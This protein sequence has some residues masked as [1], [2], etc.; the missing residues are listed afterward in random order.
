MFNTNSL[1][2]RLIILLVVFAFLPACIS[3]I[4]SGYM[5]SQSIIES[6]IVAN[7]SMAN[8]VGDEIDLLLEE[9]RKE[10]EILAATPTAKSMDATAVKELILGAQK[11][12]PSF[13]LIVVMDT[14]GNQIART[15]GTLTN[16][17]DRIYFQEAMK[18]HTFF[19]D[20]YISAFTKAPC[21]TVAVPVKNTMGQVVGVVA[22]D[23]SLKVV[24]DIIDVV[25]VGEKG[26]IDVV[27]NKG[28]IVAHPDK[29][30]VLQKESFTTYDYVAKVIEGQRDWMQGVSTRGEQSL[31]VYSS[32][33]R[34]KW[35]VI[36]QEPMSEV[37]ASVIHSA[38]VTG[39]ITLVAVLIALISAY[40]VARSIV[41]P[42][43]KLVNAAD[44][45]ANGDLGHSIEIQGVAEITKLSEAFDAMIKAL[46]RL[47]ATT[48]ATAETVSASSEELA[49]SSG[50]VGKA[51]E[52]VAITI[53]SVAE[54]ANSQVNLADQ[55]AQV[56]RD[57]V[58]AISNTSKAAD[59]V[60]AASEQSERAA[61]TGSKQ[62]DMAVTK[63]NEI[64]QDSNQAAQKVHALGEKSR[65]IGQIVDV[66]TGIAGQTNL[67]ALNA[68]IE[69]A[70]AGEQGR[71]FAVVADEVRK[72]AEQSETAAREI[73]GIIQA[74]QAE[75]IETVEA[76]DKSGR[77]ISSG[78]TVVATSGTA[79]KE[80]HDAIKNVREEVVRIVALTGEQQQRSGQ[81]ESAVN[82]IAAS[83]RLNAV[84]SEQVAA[85]SQEQNASVQE[86]T[87]A[88]SALAQMAAKL[89]QAVM[90]FKL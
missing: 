18:E 49:A 3:G 54:G 26:Y 42:L 19:T 61:E 9:S 33:V 1:K 73:A 75:T 72:L 88:S 37:M 52:E 56:I 71:G 47:V 6:K 10:T 14:K 79:F 4:I 53:Q 28:T 83:A 77:E 21:V 86:I 70:R 12:N 89:Q 59:S 50:E 45:V 63:M 58:E 48:S 90:K 39:V 8:L 57:M 16:R 46:R 85:A 36:V 60:A 64:Q 2:I 35:G 65:Q 7:Q 80:I 51:A 66:I 82:S 40:Y 20:V 5:N 69:A 29:E 44:R 74:I 11:N 55:S 13:E 41:R 25:Q 78:V 27:D 15:S 32:I 68:A 81:V 84:S 22:T 23:V 24:W 31:I 62:I 87:A 30:R 38:V 17:A 43:E 76:I 34:N 67:L